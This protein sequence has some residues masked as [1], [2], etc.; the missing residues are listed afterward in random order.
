[1]N[2]NEALKFFESMSE[3]AKDD[4]NCVKLAHNTDF[5]D[6]DA[7]YI[8]KY[9]DKDTDIL[10]IGTGTGLI[11]NKIFDK[12][13]S[14]E[15]LEPFSE[16]TQH[17]I[18]NKNITIVNDNIFSYKTNKKF[19]IV[20]IFGSMHYFNKDEAEKIYSLVFSLLNNNGVLII[21]NQFGVKEDVVVSGYSEEQKTNYF[22]SYRHIDKETLLLENIGYKNIKVVD[23]YPPEANRWDNTH[24]YAIVAEK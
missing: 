6:I 15:C 14:I 3:H 8:L 16:F 9:A 22:A 24:F 23:I 12:V 19:D 21:K 20:T 17:I 2:N 7:S 4:K 11:V 18:K 10:D 5:T 13:K 1:M